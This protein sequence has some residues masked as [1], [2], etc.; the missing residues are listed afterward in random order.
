LLSRIVPLP[1]CCENVQTRRGKC[2]VAASTFIA[3]ALLFQDMSISMI[4]Y[5]ATISTVR[6][7]THKTLGGVYLKTF[8]YH[9]VLYRNCQA[10]TLTTLGS[11]IA[12]ECVRT[13]HRT[14]NDEIAITGWVLFQSL[15]EARRRHC[16][17]RS[18]VTQTSQVLIFSAYLASQTHGLQHNSVS[19]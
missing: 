19:P 13:L 9:D 7:T 16:V 6:I 1:Y 4:A 3:R 5:S 14:S 10:R 18:A 2:C 12:S 15:A 8:F 17:F 11:C